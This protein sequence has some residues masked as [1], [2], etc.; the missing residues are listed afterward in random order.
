MT[1]GNVIRARRLREAK[2]S[3]YG[4]S[5]IL[6]VDL[7]EVRRLLDE[8]AAETSRRWAAVRAAEDAERIFSGG[9]NT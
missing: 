1:E 4:I 6:G 5:L 8:N 3:H 2:V 7:S 9:D